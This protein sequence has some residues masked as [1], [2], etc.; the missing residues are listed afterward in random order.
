[1]EAAEDIG[2]RLAI[3]SRP[4][5]MNMYHGDSDYNYKFHRYKYP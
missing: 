5:D 1:M 4:R 3:A 2:I